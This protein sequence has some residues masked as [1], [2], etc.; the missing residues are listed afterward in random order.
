MKTQILSILVVTVSVVV[1]FGGCKKDDTSNTNSQ[2]LVLKKINQYIPDV[3]IK[4]KVKML[5]AFREKAVAKESNQLKSAANFEDTPADLA[6]YLLETTL[7]TDYANVYDSTLTN[8]TNNTVEIEVS[9]NG[10]TDEGLPILDGES[11]TEAY[12][13]LEQ[14]AEALNT[15]TTTFYYATVQIETYDESS[16]T[17]QATV[18]SAEGAPNSYAHVPIVLK[19]WEDPVP[20]NSNES[21]YPVSDYP[22]PW[23]MNNPNPNWAGAKIAAKLNA[24]YEAIYS[25]PVSGIIMER[26]LPDACF[27]FLDD[28]GGSSIWGEYFYGTPLNYTQLNYYLNSYK[29]FMDLLNTPYGYND[30][31]V[32]RAY[33]YHYNSLANTT[34]PSPYL[35][36]NNHQYYTDWHYL[37]F[38]RMRFIQTGNPN[39]E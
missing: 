20:F 32:M 23:T 31:Y 16:T 5:N 14:A 15:E 21:Y 2:E 12:L 10:L 19:P 9:N 1:F 37:V 24:H 8:V 7:N 11:L 13:D 26:I 25:L 30:T 29:A 34:P 6:R 27:S 38:S 22:Y 39:G 28:C 17:I 3:D 4:T 18:S 36:P 35:C 33:V